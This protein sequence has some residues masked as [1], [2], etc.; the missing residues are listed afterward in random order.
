[1]EKRSHSN[2]TLINGKDQLE[3]LEKSITPVLRGYAA[4]PRHLNL[5]KG[6]SRLT[7]AEFIKDWLLRE[8]QWREDRFRRVVV[9]FPDE[10]LH[11]EG[12][13]VTVQ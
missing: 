7:I 2:W 9:F 3:E 8:D 10:V 11:L 12:G 5:V 1:M 4:D 13:A 6:K